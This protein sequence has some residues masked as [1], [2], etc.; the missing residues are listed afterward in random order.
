M[1]PKNTLATVQSIASQ[2]LRN[3]ASVGQA[4]EALESR[5]LALSR[6]HDVLTRESWDGAD[7]GEIVT[8][9]VEPF[10]NP[11]GKRLR[12]AGPPVRLSPRIALA[13]SMAF[14]E[15]ATNAV[16]YGALSNGTGVVRIG[17]SVAYG[18]DGR[19]R[20]HVRWEE[21]GGPTV[22]PP[23]RRGFGSRLLERVLAHDLDGDV[24]LEFAATG[25]VC[26]LEADAA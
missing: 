9:A 6:A 16:K 5:L 13:L 2:T 17:W 22:R 19:P 7:M 15:L 14:Q 26:T 18:R 1:C 24:T 12:F 4:H 8:R 3:A 25:V 23:G 11:D 10:G 21:T 20:L